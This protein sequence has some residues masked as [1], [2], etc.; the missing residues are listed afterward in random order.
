MLYSG[1]E[2]QLFLVFKVKDRQCDKIGSLEF[3]LKEYRSQKKPETQWQAI[4]FRKDLPALGKT[5]ETRFFCGFSEGP[6]QNNPT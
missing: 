2:L 4:T 3:L 1:V 6:G 5:L